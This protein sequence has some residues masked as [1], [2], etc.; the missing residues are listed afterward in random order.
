[1]DNPATH[2]I[3]EGVEYADDDNFPKPTPIEAAMEY[4]TGENASDRA[5]DDRDQLLKGD[6]VIVALRGCYETTA[7]LEEDDHFDGYEAGCTYW[8]D[9]KDRR[10][11]QLQ[12]RA[13]LLP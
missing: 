12:V 13:E 3:P 5:W 2:W 4:V 1:M 7:P 10:R 6:P 11:V 8:M 9:T